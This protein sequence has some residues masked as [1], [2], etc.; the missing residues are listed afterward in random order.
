MDRGA[1]Q[2][3]VHGVAESE[4]TDVNEHTY[5]QYNLYIII[6]NIY[7]YI[8]THTH[9]HTVDPKGNQPEYSWEGLMLKLHYFGHLM[10]RAGSL[11][12]TLMLARLRAKRRRRE[13]QRM[14]QLDSTTDAMAMTQ[15]K[16]WEMVKDRESR[17]ATVHGVEKHQ[18]LLSD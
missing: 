8:D 3:V 18:T 14:R 7:V 9:A 15:G 11:E 5:I 17:C 2:A 10:Q 16:L 4:M 12:K 13:Q 1:W 6:Y